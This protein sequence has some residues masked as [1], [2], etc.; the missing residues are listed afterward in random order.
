MVWMDVQ[1]HSLIPRKKVLSRENLQFIE[2][3][4]FHQREGWVMC[5]FAKF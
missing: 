2:K 4:K 5:N 3:R 1:L